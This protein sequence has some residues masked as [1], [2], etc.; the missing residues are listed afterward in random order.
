MGENFQR[1]GSV[2]NAHVGRDFETAAIKALAEAGIEVVKNYTVEIGVADVKKSHTFDMGSDSPPTI[3]ECKSHRW[4]AGGNVPSA[5]MIVWNEAMYYFAC[6]PNDYRKILFVLRDSHA[7]S[8]ESLS[9]YYLRMYPHLIPPGVEIWEFD[10]A[11]GKAK[12]VYST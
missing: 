1:V 9:Q 8:G 4:T 7:T 11:K 3:V 2:S 5:K 10:D 6:A 12:I